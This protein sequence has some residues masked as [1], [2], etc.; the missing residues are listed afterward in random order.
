[1]SEAAL[2]PIF[3]VGPHRSGTTLLSYLLSAHPAIAITAETHFLSTWTRL[4]RH[5]NLDQHHDAQLFWEA[6]KQG[7]QLRRLELDPST[8]EQF[9]PET[10]DDRRLFLSIMRAYADKKGKRRIGEKTPYH[11]LHIATLL[12]WFPEAR[13]ICLQ[14]DPRAVVQSA[15]T[16]PWANHSIYAQCQH[17]N[18]CVQA[19]QSF[20]SD[21]RVHVVSY[22]ELVTD[23]EA[24][25]RLICHHIH[26][27][28]DPAML[29]HA[30]VTSMSDYIH[31]QNS[32]GSANKHMLMSPVT[33]SGVDKWRTRLTPNQIALVDHCCGDQMEQ[34]GYQTESSSLTPVQSIIA[35][36]SRL[37]APIGRWRIYRNFE[38]RLHLLYLVRTWIASRLTH[39]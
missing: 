13:I 6:Y 31:V 22:E 15:I 12:S 26:E 3:I 34:L 33:A 20:A 16:A 32:W 29:N 19:S 2:R 24:E 7:R 35:L 9:F 10:L 23:P 18:K 17:W 39:D 36:A 21:E 4:Y 25:L 38:K 37:Y 28:F 1:M 14:R 11:I 27:E 5:L 8:V 30:A